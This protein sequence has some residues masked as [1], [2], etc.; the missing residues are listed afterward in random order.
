ML[1][2]TE[3]LD[4]LASWLLILEKIVEQSSN[5]VV[6]TDAE[7]RIRWVNRTYTRV[8]GWD[9]KEVQGKRAGEFLKGPK[10]DRRVTELVGHHLRQGLSISSVETVNYR[11]NGD[12]YAVSLSIEPIRDSNGNPVAYF[13]IQSDITER[14]TLEQ[15]NAHL[16]HH[17]LMAQRLARLGRVEFHADTR[18]MR[19]SSEVYSILEI[20]KDNGAPKSLKALLSHVMPFAKRNLLGRRR[21]VL[22]NGDE[23]DH[24]LPITTR[25]GQ[26]RWVRCRGVPE[27]DGENVLPP[28]TWTLQ[29]VTVY[30]ELIEQKRL[31]NQSC[32]P[33]WRSERATLRRPIGRWKRSRMRFHMTSKSRSGTW[34]AMPRFYRSP[35][36]VASTQA[37]NLTFSRCSA[38]PIR[39]TPLSGTAS[40]WRFANAS[41]RH[42][43][44]ASGPNPT[45][46]RVLS[47]SCSCP[48]PGT[49]TPR[50]KR[51]AT[52]S[53]RTGPCPSLGPAGSPR[54][55][56]AGKA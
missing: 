32:K 48:A 12:P 14:R 17:L 20:P 53:E 25:N 15:A 51:H 23:F 10:T 40:A 30:R 54:N 7:Q 4:D 11:K 35:W 46:E 39:T 19:W 33:W 44:A 24:E 45:L 52:T 29:D 49:P 1:N 55:P 8:T 47:F 41:S 2:D 22:E 3:K 18:R 50:V 36:L 28:S 38:E 5:M 9:L 37:C 13:S 16:Q 27:H 21:Q 6:I 42:T 26:Q 43:G 34:S 56:C 31:T